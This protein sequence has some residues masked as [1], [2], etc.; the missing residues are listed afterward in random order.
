MLK[1]MHEIARLVFGKIDVNHLGFG[2]LQINLEKLSHWL[3]PIFLK[4]EGH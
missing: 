2:G 1:K 3:M 4:V